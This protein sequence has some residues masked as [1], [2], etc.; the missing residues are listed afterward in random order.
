MPEYP[1]LR[2][3]REKNGYTQKAISEYL[4]MKQPQYLRYEK[5]LR[6]LP[7]DVLISLAYKYDTSIDYL[8][9]VTDVANSYPKTKGKIL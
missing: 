1:R 6:D 3:L 9:G 2:L 8:L 5:G 4:N 7:T